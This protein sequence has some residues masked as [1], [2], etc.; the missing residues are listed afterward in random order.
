[1]LPSKILELDKDA[2]GN[3]RRSF[4]RC[5]RRVRGL[6]RH[7]LRNLREEDGGS[8]TE[9]AISISAALTL[10]FVLMQLCIALYT[11]GMISETAREATRWAAVRGSTCKNGAGA[12][13]ATTTSAITTYAQ[14][15]G[16]PNIGSGTITVT[17]TFPQSCQAPPTCTVNVLVTYTV[18]VKLPLVPNH[19]ISMQSSS[20][21][22]FVQ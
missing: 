8:L 11:Y 19:S 18:P 14:G 5:G 6:R 12:S 16:F 15:L 21:M 2:R 10:I 7:N 17:P 3:T 4:S 20:A 1:M 13:C 22:Y 9:F